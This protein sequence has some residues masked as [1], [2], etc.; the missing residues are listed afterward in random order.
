MPPQTLILEFQSLKRTRRYGSKVRT[1]CLTC[2]S[3]RIKC[4]ETK[5]ACLRCTSTR[6]LCDGYGES[7]AKQPKRSSHN[8]ASLLQNTPVTQSWPEE[9]LPYLEFYYHCAIRTLSNRFDNN[10][11]SR[12]VLQ[13]ARS[14]Q[15]IRHALVALGYLAKT[16]PGNL[17][18]AHARLKQQDQKLNL[19]YSKAVG[20]LVERL[21][22]PLCTV[23]IGLV[24]CLLFVC[25]EFIRGNFMTAFTHL[26]SGL[27]ILSELPTIRTHGLCPRTPQQIS[28]KADTVRFSAS[29]GLLNE[30]L[31]PMF[32]RNITPAMLFGAPIEDLFEIP[33][34]DPSIFDI[35]FSTLYDL[36]MS[37]FQLRNAS[38]L[39]AR[40]MATTIFIKV[41]LTPEDFAQQ[42]Q[43]LEAHHAWFRAMQK[44]EQA[45]FL[46]H[47]DEIMAAALKLGYYSTYILI[48]CAMSLRQVNFDAHLDYFKA[49][50]HNAKIILDSMGIVT[51]PLPVSSGT[52][53]GLSRKYASALKAA[54]SR[55]TTA[56]VHFTFEIS[57]VPPLH[58]VAT[59][60]RHPLVRREAVALLK[61]NPPREGLWDV[62]THIAVAE[63]VIAIEESV[64]DPATGWPA[65]SARLWCSVHDGK[66]YSDGK[67]LVTFAFADWADQRVPQ[68]NDLRHPNGGDR[69]DAQWT[70][71]IG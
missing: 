70:E 49:I 51:P 35:P 21:A 64:L 38:A 17:K 40:K 31:I 60:C 8:V 3:R 71:K 33:I 14:E 47:E 69:S 63:R 28:P 54:G 22:E 67:I 27:K 10:F 45:A 6:R 12:T 15:C 19:Y 56:G 9:G 65:E 2:K 66:G 23:E 36:Q 1:G 48:D 59:R 43:L 50:N 55:N 57:V 24:A 20:S 26:H 11:W 42:S 46:A 53:R 29:N 39:F 25:I 41:P 16:E 30:T 7:G 32:M 18:H 37:S 62:D 5:P 52:R 13:M 58:F 61:T 34:P 68:A 4:D 44:L